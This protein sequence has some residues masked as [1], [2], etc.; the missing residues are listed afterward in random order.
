[1]LQQIDQK[2]GAS[3]LLRKN[4][5]NWSYSAWKKKRL[6]GDLTAAFQYLKGTYWKDEAR[7]LRS[8]CSDKGNGFKL[9]HRR[10]RLPISKEFI[11]LRIVRDRNR[12]RREAVHASF[13]E[14]Q[15]QVGWVSEQFRLLEGAL[16][17]GQEGWN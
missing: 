12:L 8:A 9:K 10:F 4:A 7:L 15:D 5:D 2:D 11:I 6:Q 3:L 17:Y 1:M 14:V 16:A 13:L